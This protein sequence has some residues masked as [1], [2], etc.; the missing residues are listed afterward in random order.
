VYSSCFFELVLRTLLL[1]GT[2]VVVVL[3]LTHIVIRWLPG[4]DDGGPARTKNF[5]HTPV[6]VQRGILEVLRVVVMI[7]Y[8]QARQGGILSHCFQRRK[9]DE[10]TLAPLHNRIWRPDLIDDGRAG[11]SR[12][13]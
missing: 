4:A 12:N 5:L 7:L 6:L 11:R 8:W 10:K 1:R 3:L 9:G 13:E 2:T